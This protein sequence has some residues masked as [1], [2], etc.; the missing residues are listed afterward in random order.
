MLLLPALNSMID[1]TTTRAVAIQ[2]HPPR[3]IF[4]LLA[5][6]S[7]AS[8]LLAGHVMCG[9]AARSWFYMLLFAS[10]MSVTFL[11]LV[12]LRNLVR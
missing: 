4:V 3:I 10:I 6:L 1:M 8:A 2:D 7:L 9:T 5:V 12:E 11:V